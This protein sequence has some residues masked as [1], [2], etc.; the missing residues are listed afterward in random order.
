[1]NI[2]NIP[3]TIGVISGLNECANLFLWV[4]SA[5]SSL[6]SQ[7]NETQKERLQAGDIRQLQSDIQCLIDTLSA[8]DD[9]IDRAE[10][11]IHDH[12]V[13]DHLSRLKDAV[14]DAEDLLDELRWYETKLSVEGN[15]ISVEPIIEFFHSVIQ[16]SF[17][18]VTDIQKRLNQLSGHL[19]EMGL[20]QEVPRFEKS[21]RPETTSFP[22]EQRFLG[23]VRKR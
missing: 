3:K 11:R 8:M 19:E 10:W 13:V 5:I 17:N 12:Y 9:L 7:S 20:R 21:F 15:A 6:E 22:T 23:V 4:T 18:K 1:M 14:Y 16:G 2:T